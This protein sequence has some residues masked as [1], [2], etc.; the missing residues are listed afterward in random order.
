ML[1]RG[2]VGGESGLQAWPVRLMVVDWWA[3]WGPADGHVWCACVG[4]LLRAVCWF[5]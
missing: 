1:L 3:V 5:A 4:V 2:V